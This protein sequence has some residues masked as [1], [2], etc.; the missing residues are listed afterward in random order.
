MTS[1]KNFINGNIGNI[2][3]F[4]IFTENNVVKSVI[5]ECNNIGVPQGSIAGPKFVIYPYNKLY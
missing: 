2:V 3:K 4:K 5:I 1:L